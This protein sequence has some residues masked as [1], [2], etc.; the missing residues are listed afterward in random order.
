MADRELVLVLGTYRPAVTVVRALARRG[1]RAVVG[2]EPDRRH[3]E[4][5]AGVEFSRHTTAVWDHPSIKDEPGFLD[6]LVRELAGWPEPGHVLPL[7]EAALILLA[8]ERS[9]LPAGTSLAVP[10]TETIITCLDKERC[11]HAARTA[12]LPV[13]PWEVVRGYPELLAAA[14]RAAAPVVVKPL[15]PHSRLLGDRKAILCRDGSDLAR[16][17]PVWPPGH[18]RLLVQRLAEGPRHNLYFAARGG[19]LLDVVEV[20]TVRTDRRDGTGLGITGHTR[21]V[22]IGLREQ[23]TALVAHL[24][25]TGVGFGQFL[26]QP[27]ADGAF[28]ELNPRV[29]GSYVIADHAG[30]DLANLAV[31][32]A[33]DVPVEP[34]IPAPAGRDGHTYAWTFGDLAGLW[35]A[36]GQGE[37][38]RAGALAELARIARTAA[39]ADVHLTWSWRDPVP[40]IATY[41]RYLILSS[42]RLIAASL[43]DRSTT[44]SPAVAD[45]ELV[46]VLGTYRPAVTVVRALARRGRRA[47]VGREPDRRHSEGSAGVEFSRHTTAVWDHPSIKDE[48]GFLDALVRE[49]AG[50]PEPGHV[51]PL[52][53][54]ALILLARERSRLPAGTSLAVPATETIITCLDKERCLHAAQAAG[55]P[56]PPWEVVRGY[57]ELLAAAGRAAA[58]VVVK[59]LWPHSRLLDNR[60]AI[61]CRDGS[62]LARQLPVWPAGH[63]RLLV[64]RLAKGPRHNLNFA[65]RDGELLDVVEVLTVRTD[66]RDGTG[67]GVEGH[68]RP[69][70][71][72]LR[73]QLAALVAHL[74]YTGVGCGQFLVQPGA[75][76]GAFLELNPRLDANYVIADHAGF[77][78]AN[79]AVDLAADVP[80]EPRIPAP[81][82]RDGHT[83]AWTFGDLAGL[84]YAIG[85][86][87]LTRAGALAELARIARTAALADVHLTWTW[88]DPLPTITTYWRY[89]ILS[90]LRLIAEPGTD[91]R[92]R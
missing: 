86:G 32:L 83:F 16:Q 18:D 55:L 45:R 62:D 25:Y 56:V 7:D 51:L 53:D 24:R 35:Y 38:T 67:L 42:L 11:L 76:D 9:R 8:R 1:R 70:S 75:Q 60:K 10:A 80:V 52:D 72:G 39:L 40:T 84:W 22:S 54:V 46:L 68:T 58:P 78:L 48:P 50:W 49:L 64:Q 47:V 36:I 26:V 43:V 5:S 2:R 34:R 27:G 69:V 85:R 74:R 44:R 92:R 63:D 41:W 82:N 21:P 37:L 71:I 4:G 73:E 29:S 65:A 19:E 90:T 13:P 17:L 61:L 66:R 15:W 33:A 31:D 20:L 89:L 81:T 30:L 79:L 28:I 87:E 59:P 12:G 14:G 91:R 3:S 57:P 6:A 23:L 77:D 88:R